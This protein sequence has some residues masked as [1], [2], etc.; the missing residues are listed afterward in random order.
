V[1]DVKPY[2]DRADLYVAPLRL[3]EGIKGKIL[4]A[5]AAGVPVVTSS[6]GSR[7][8]SARSGEHLLVADKPDDFAEAAVRVAFDR[9]LRRRL[10]LNARRLAEEKYDWRKLAGGVFEF[11]REFLST[12]GNTKSLKP[13]SR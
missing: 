4:E 3:G 6:V 11:Y 10:V 1:P 12:N 13:S 5:F 8:L 9:D 7:G 2:L